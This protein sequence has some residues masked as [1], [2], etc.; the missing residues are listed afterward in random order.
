MD[1]RIFIVVAIM[2]FAQ[3]AAFSPSYQYKVCKA[4]SL[5]SIF[6]SQLLSN[7]FHSTRQPSPT[8]LRAS[9]KE[10]GITGGGATV[11]ASP[12]KDKKKNIRTESNG[13]GGDGEDWEL[14]LFNDETN[15]RS[16][17]ADCLVTIVGLSEPRAY[18]A[19]MSAHTNGRGSCGEY[20]Q[21]RAEIYKEE[22]QNKGLTVG[23]HP[24]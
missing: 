5:P 12:V 21:E 19:M 2:A 4:K 23:I 24:V 15:Y 16:Y 20:C 9:P 22:L 8:S 6:S 1:H 14:T 11:I 10:V 18:Q 3:T 13:G 7:I 17:V